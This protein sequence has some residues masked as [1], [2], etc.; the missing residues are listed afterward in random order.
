ETCVA[1]ARQC[2]RNRQLR[3]SRDVL[4]LGRRERVQVDR[5][6]R[7]DRAEEILVVVDPEIRMVAALHQETGATERERLLDLL[8]DNR[9]REE[10]SLARVAWTA[11]ERAEVAV[12]VADVRVVEVA[13]DDER[14]P[15][16]VGSSVA[17][18][19]RGATH[20]DEI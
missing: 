6:A 1:K 9:L 16:R 2:F 14:D 10:I 17:E 7:L 3:P 19:V 18:L 15:R 13:V 20:C 11:V 8:E 4:H 12:R 5:I